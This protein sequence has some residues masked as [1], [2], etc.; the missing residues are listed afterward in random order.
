MKIILNRKK[1]GIV[2]PLDRVYGEPS[3]TEHFLR[4][5]VGERMFRASSVVIQTSNFKHIFTLTLEIIFYYILKKIVY[6]I[7]RYD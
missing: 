3:V 5:E 2:F 1:S 6:N 7:C 4:N